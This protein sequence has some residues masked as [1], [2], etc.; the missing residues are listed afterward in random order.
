[1]SERANQLAVL[2]SA[3]RV[4][5]LLKL[6][7]DEQ[8]LFAVAAPQCAERF[9]SGPD[10]AVRLGTACESRASARISVSSG[11]AST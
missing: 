2:L 5:P 11:V 4:Q 10:L 3:V 9:R 1:L 6:I 7:D 8:Q